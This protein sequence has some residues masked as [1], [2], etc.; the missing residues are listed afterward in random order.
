M[1]TNA[2]T[3]RTN[4]TLRGGA[5]PNSGPKPKPIEERIKPVLV[6]L[7]PDLIQKLDRYS[8]AV[9]KESKVSKAQVIRIALDLLRMDK[10]RKALR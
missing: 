3:H 10:L 4:T 5:R 2:R 8:K 6:G 1:S 7:S 9:S